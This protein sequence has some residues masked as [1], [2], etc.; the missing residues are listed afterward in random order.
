MME[1]VFLYWA[2][3]LFICS[4]GAIALSNITKCLSWRS[5]PDPLVY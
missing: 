1:M 2:K 4:A 3:D 5:N